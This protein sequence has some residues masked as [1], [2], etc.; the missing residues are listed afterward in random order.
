MHTYA[1]QILLLYY[2]V[3]H[4]PRF[5]HY[6]LGIEV[7]KNLTNESDTMLTNC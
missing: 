7:E 2:Q 3:N 6:S 4:R 1:F 5:F